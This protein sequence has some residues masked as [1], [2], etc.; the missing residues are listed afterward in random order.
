MLDIE[1]PNEPHGRSL[2]PLLRG[3]T[4]R[5][6]ELL[7]YGTFA[8]GCVVSDED[9]TLAQ[10]SRP[11]GPLNWY[12]TTGMNSAPDMTSGHFIPGVEIPQWRVPATT[13]GLS[14]LPLEPAR[15]SHW[16]HVTCTRREP[17]RVRRMQELLR[18]GSGGMRGAAGNAGAPGAGLEAAM[19]GEPVAYG[20][21]ARVFLRLSVTAFGGPVAHIALAEDELVTRRRWLTR[22]HYLEPDRC[23]QP[24]PR[25]QLHRGHDPRRPQFARHSLARW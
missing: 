19:N 6:R 17:A 9:W 21:L 25:P 22:D 18:A 15:N 11:E 13:A 23:R 1:Q 2:M 8:A 7:L 20:E 16:R 10:S 24:D 5:H 12:S 14:G 3:E 4:D